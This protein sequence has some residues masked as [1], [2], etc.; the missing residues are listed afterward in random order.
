[1]AETVKVKRD[2]DV[3][4]VQTAARHWARRLGFAAKAQW[5]VA[6]AASEAATN[7]LKHAGG[8]VIVFR[9]LEGEKPGMIFEARDQGPG[10]QD[11]AQAMEDGYSEGGWICDLTDFRR[12]RGLG[13]GL[14]AI[15]RMM[16]QV[17]IQ[18]PPEGGALLT[19]VKYLKF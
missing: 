5:E 3:C 9:N 12:R 14:P 2:A 10:I 11:P 6:I 18:S 15:K 8:G 7:M 16:D 17:I 19:A 1:M 13:S 4:N